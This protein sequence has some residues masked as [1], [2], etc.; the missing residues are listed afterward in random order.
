M[1]EREREIEYYARS[2]PLCVCVCRQ[3]LLAPDLKHLQWGCKD[4][5]TDIQEKDRKRKKHTNNN[6]KNSKV[7]ISLK[8]CW[9]KIQ[10]DRL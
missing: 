9:G 5:Q 6:K 7:G 1:E 3:I 4:I 2:Q 8:P 10:K